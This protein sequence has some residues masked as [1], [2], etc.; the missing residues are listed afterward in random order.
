MAFEIQHAELFAA[1]IYRKSPG[2]PGP[3]NSKTSPGEFWEISELEDP[4]NGPLQHLFGLGDHKPPKVPPD[5]EIR[6]GYLNI[7]R[8]NRPL[9]LL[10]LDGMSAAKCDF[11]PMDT[12]DF[13]LLNHTD[14]R[15]SDR[16]RATDLC[17]LAKGWG[18]EGYIRM[19]AGF[20]IIKC[21]FSEGL[22]F[23]SQKR[24]PDND[25]P[26][27]YNS[28]FLLDYIREVS[29]RYH[30]IDSGRVSLDY[31]SMVSAYFYPTNLSN[32]NPDPLQ[33][34]LPRLVRSERAVLER[35]KSDLGEAVK[36]SKLHAGVDWQG[37]ADM[38]VKRYSSRLQ[39][40]ATNPTRKMC[41]SQ[42]NSLL[43]LFVEYG[44][45]ESEDPVAAC[46]EHY[47]RPVRSSTKQ[48]QLIQAAVKTVTGRICATLFQVREL[49][50]AKEK[51]ND[52]A[53][54]KNLDPAIDLI[55]NLMAWLN[56]SDWKA[57][58][59]C[60]YDQV[61]FVAVFPFGT[62][63]YHYNPHCVNSTEIEASVGDTDTNYWQRRTL[64][65]PDELVR[66]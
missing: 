47:L 48:D 15:F 37:V 32:P 25:K 3:D 46:S 24:R 56:W 64:H 2:H 4:R 40:L 18:V 7:Y 10:Y 42:I 51:S 50:L 38:I 63:E 55:R 22:D 44:D 1:L 16:M 29:N 31:S 49:L 13:L 11:G 52:P 21:N 12:Q 20:E 36:R 33:S 43:N 59:Q 17:K 19:E 39:Y 8:T 28:M 41:L 5:I 58:E 54:I 62:A 57:C 53:D 27:G 30:G 45:S 23:I 26:E 6:P 14:Y 60:A 65:G 34:D 9:K 66:W 35:I 61:C